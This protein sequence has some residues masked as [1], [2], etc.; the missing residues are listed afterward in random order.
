[1]IAVT[2]TFF[3]VQY[4]NAMLTRMTAIWNLADELIIRLLLRHVW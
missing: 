4:F 1:M 3:N 2:I